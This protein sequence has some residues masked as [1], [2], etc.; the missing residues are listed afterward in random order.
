MKETHEFDKDYWERHWRQRSGGVA[1]P[2][3]HV[4]RETAELV[5]GTALDAGCGAGTEARWLARRG[6]QVTAADIS[7]A[8][9]ARA[10]GAEDVRWV[11]ADLATW[12]PGRTFDLVLTCYAHPA[13]PQLRFYDRLAGWV[14]PGGTLLI[15]G[16][17]SGDQH[18]EE[19]TATASAVAAR[20]D[21]ATWTIVTA[22]EPSRTVHGGP[23]G[24]LHDVVVRATRAAV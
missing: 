2:N 8:A 22:E 6:W 17:R 11:E 13:M 7:A 3:P 23:A 9:L 18:P 19:A 12:D 16:H 5:A 20:L 1:D 21:S 24:K 10:N 15:V 4:V 14:A